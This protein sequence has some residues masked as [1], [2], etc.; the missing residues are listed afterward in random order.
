MSG[1][2]VDILPSADTVEA[3]LAVHTT[4]A[5]S[6]VLAR[7]ARHPSG[8]IGLALTVLLVALTVLGPV[9]TADPDTAD[10]ANKLQGP[11]AEHL[12]GTDEAGRDQLARIAAG[13]RTTLGAAAAIFVLTTTIGLALGSTAGLAGGLV[14]SLLSR[15]V[16]VMLGIPSLIL[17]LAVVGALGPSLRNLIIAMTLGGWAYPARLARSY[18]LGANQ[19]P[20]VVA[21]R[22]AGVGPLRRAFGHV[23]PGVVAQLMIAATLELSSIIL[24]LSALSFLGLGVQPP[25]AE[26]GRMLAESRDVVNRAP[27]LALAPGLAIMAAVAASLLISEALRDVTDPSWQR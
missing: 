3:P 10:F 15:L 9:L 20:D 16:D 21:A 26:W 22:M 12:L 19:R 7:L 11:S 6:S 14:D 4:S 18:V 23:L 24:G 25:T 1:A 17:A 5:S 8:R 13:A 2:D 27:E